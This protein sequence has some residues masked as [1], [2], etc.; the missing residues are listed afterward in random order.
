MTE[1]DA[2]PIA[3]SELAE[4][5]RDAER[6]AWCLIIL[7][8][9]DCEEANDKTMFI[10]HALLSGLDGREAIDAAMQANK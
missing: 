5:R 1:H 10:A 6:F 2:V 3:T 4:L 7:T 8:G 9:A